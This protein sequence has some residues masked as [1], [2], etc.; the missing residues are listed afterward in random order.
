MVHKLT[1][2][3]TI[4]FFLLLFFLLPQSFSFGLVFLYCFSNIIVDRIIFRWCFASF[5]FSLTF[6]SSSS[7][8]WIKYL[9][10]V[11]YISFISALITL[12]IISS[13]YCFGSQVCHPHRFSAETT[14]CVYIPVR[15]LIVSLSCSSFNN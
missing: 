12:F 9:F 8:V 15:V 1:S 10:C 14:M 5:S 4:L 3:S 7:F 11:R 13:T 2:F 6:I